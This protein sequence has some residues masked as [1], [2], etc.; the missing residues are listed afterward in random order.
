MRSRS[1]CAVTSCLLLLAAALSTG[2]LAARQPAWDRAVELTPVASYQFGS[3]FEVDDFDLGRVDLEID[4]GAGYG[5]ILDIDLTRSIQ[6]ELLAVRQESELELDRGFR[7]P[8]EP[9]GDVDLDYLHAGVL[10]HGILGQVQPFGVF[11]IGATRL[12]ADGFDSETYPSVSL[13]G[14]VKLLFNDRIGARFEGRFFA[15]ALD[16]DDD[17]CRRRRSRDDGDDLVQGF[18]AAGLILR[19]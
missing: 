3:S 4:D 17:C 16:E 7:S 9:L 18:V 15:T 6:L 1:R 8:A 11:T 2:S 13:G 19:F 5:A 14:G 10:W 12:D